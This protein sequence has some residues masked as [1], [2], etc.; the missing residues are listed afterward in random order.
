MKLYAL[1]D[2]DESEF[3]EIMRNLEEARQTIYECYSRLGEIGVL[4]IKN[5]TAVS[6]N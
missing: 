3:A 6:G 5:E 4:T 2:I 1:V